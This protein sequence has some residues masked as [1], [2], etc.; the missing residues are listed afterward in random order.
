MRLWIAQGFGVGRIP[1]AP[2]TLGSAIGLVWFGVL[3][4][5]GH[6]WSYVLGMA[7][8]LGLSVWLCGSAEKILREK[9]PSSVVL[10]EITAMPVCFS[11]WIGIWISRTGR[12]PALDSLVG[13]SNALLI[14][15]IFVLFRLFDVWKPWPVRESQELPGGWGVTIDD[16]LAACYVALIVLVVMGAKTKWQ[17]A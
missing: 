5:T 2:G 13:E 15:G 12:L 3:L 16:V 7:A 9:D 1:Y 8:G 6:V 10:D 4:A 14:A 17:A 11:S